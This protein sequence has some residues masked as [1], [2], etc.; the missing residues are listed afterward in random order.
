MQVLSVWLVLGGIARADAEEEHSLEG[1][2]RTTLLRE[3]RLSLLPFRVDGH[4]VLTWEGD[5]GLGLR[6]DIPI[7]DKSRLYNARDELA[8]SVGCDFSFVSFGGGNRLTTWPTAT[9]QWTLAVTERFSFFP[10]LGLVGRVQGSEW[11]GLYPNVG[12]GGRVL[13]YQTL[14]VVGRLG[15]PM[16]VS[17]GLSF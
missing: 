2:S 10:E 17:L 14:S 4:A 5:F 6:G 12:F 15:W 9:V 1:Y 11:K 3:D 13:V 8:I 16:A 7:F